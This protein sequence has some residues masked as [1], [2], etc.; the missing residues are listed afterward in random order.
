VFIE[1]GY[2]EDFSVSVRDGNWKLI[3]TP[4]EMLLKEMGRTNPY[5][6]FDVL[7]DPGETR[8]LYESEAEV[9]A[10]LQPQLDEFKELAYLRLS[11]ALNEAVDMTDEERQRLIDMGY[12]EDVADGEEDG[13]EGSGH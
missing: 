10:R 12:L 3:L 1:S 5:Q 9:V 2:R 4:D 6:L 7:A 11:H 13:G 8:D